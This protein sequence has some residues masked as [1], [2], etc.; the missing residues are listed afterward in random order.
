MPFPLP[1]P[2]ILGHYWSFASIEL[3]VVTP[4]GLQKITEIQAVNYA[5]SL[6]MGDVWG[7]RPQKLGRTRGQQNGEASIELLMPAWE[8]LRQALGASGVGYGELP[9]DVIVSYGEIGLPVK[10][11]IIGGCRISR[12]EYANTVG[13]EA[14]KVT[15][16]L[17][18]MRILEGVTGSIVAP[19]GIG[20]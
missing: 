3:A 16:T 17:N 7:S 9:F 11:D 2:L 5:P 20:F 8:R 10:T 18:V 14:S 6:E 13:V 1:V 15:L 12:V 4:Q 19:I